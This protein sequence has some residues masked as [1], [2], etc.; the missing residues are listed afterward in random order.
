MTRWSA[1]L[2]ALLL[3]PQDATVR[4]LDAAHQPLIGEI[5]ESDRRAR[6]IAI[7]SPT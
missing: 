1:L 2:A 4:R 6:L 3:P 5:G 7:L